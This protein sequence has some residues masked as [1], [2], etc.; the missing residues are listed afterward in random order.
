MPREIAGAHRADGLGCDL[1]GLDDVDGRVRYE[2]PGQPLA[3]RGCKHVERIL[4]HTGGAHDVVVRHGDAD[5]EVAELEV[6]LTAAEELVVLPAVYVVIH[7]GARVPLRV[8]VLPAVLELLLLP[9]AVTSAVRDFVRPVDSHL[10]GLAGAERRVEVHAKLGAVEGVVRI[11]ALAG[12]I[13]ELNAG[14]RV[15]TLEVAHQVAAH[16]RIDGLRERA[17]HHGRAR[18]GPLDILVEL[19]PQVRQ[20]VGR[21][22]VVG[23]YF[24]AVQPVRGGVE[25]HLDAVVDLLL[26]VLGARSARCAAL[27]VGRRPVLERAEVGLVDLLGGVG[28]QPDLCR[29]LRG[30]RQQRDGAEE[31]SANETHSERLPF[32]EEKRATRY[33]LR[34]SSRVISIVIPT[35][36]VAPDNTSTQSRRGHFSPRS[37]RTP[38]ARTVATISSWPSSRPTLKANRGKARSASPP[39]NARR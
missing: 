21:V 24:A 30:D 26:P 2:R 8:L 29:C 10:H 16:P 25:R 23:H 22:V 31:Y 4:Q 32:N 14:Q 19:E 33:A 6:E 34:S 5:V 20:L 28:V 27:V 35:P 37:T 3:F 39:N 9:S 13:D 12:R 38:A 1:L 17:G 7:G 15:T 36:A 11:R 18:I